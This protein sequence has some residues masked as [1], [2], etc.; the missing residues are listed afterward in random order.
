M[1]SP[2]VQDPADQ[3]GKEQL[4]EMQ[5]ARRGGR[6]NEYVQDDSGFNAKALVYDVDGIAAGARCIAG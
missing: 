4:L 1:P 2:S 5:R 3:L 6:G